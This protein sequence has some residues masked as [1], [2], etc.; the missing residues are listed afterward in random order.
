MK[1]YK[2]NT[3]EKEIHNQT[4]V[5]IL[6]RWFSDEY[7][8]YLDPRNAWNALANCRE[9]GAGYRIRTKALH[10]TL[11]AIGSIGRSIK[12][13]NYSEIV[14]RFVGMDMEGPDFEADYGAALDKTVD[15]L[16]PYVGQG[17]DDATNWAVIEGIGTI[18]SHHHLIDRLSHAYVCNW[19]YAQIQQQLDNAY[20]NDELDQ[21]LV[22]KILEGVREAKTTEAFKGAL[23]DVIAIYSTKLG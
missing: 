13:P 11:S 17:E 6:S 4:L 19:R 15:A 10:T 20:A 1:Y 7:D 16:L 3:A 14:N 2:L 21:V 22:E 12:I 8:P 23:R 9:S 18:Q 5:K